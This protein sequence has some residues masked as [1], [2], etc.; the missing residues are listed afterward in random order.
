MGNIQKE[1][2]GASLFL[3]NKFF[4]CGL[5]YPAFHLLLVG[6]DGSGSSVYSLD[7]LP[8]RGG[9]KFRPF[10]ESSFPLPYGRKFLRIESR[11]PRCKILQVEKPAEHLT[12]QLF[13]KALRQ[14]IGARHLQKW[15]VQEN[16]LLIVIPDHTRNTG[17]EK[18]IQNLI[19]VLPDSLR[20]VY[21][22]VSTGSHSCTSSQLKQ[23]YSNALF[24]F[25]VELHTVNRKDWWKLGH[26]LRGT[27]I[28]I[29]PLLKEFPRVLILGGITLHYFAGFT[30]G[31]K[32][33]IPGL[34]SYSTISHNHSL[35]WNKEIHKMHTQNALRKYW[36][37]LKNPAAR[38]GNL[39][40]NPVHIDLMDAVQKIAEK[41]PLYSIQTV[42]SEP[43][44]IH[45]IFAGDW[46]K[47]FALG[48]QHIQKS[49]SIIFQKKF[50]LVIAGAGGYP[51][52][53]SLYQAHKAMDTASKFLK[54][55]GCLILSAELREG[56][57]P[58]SFQYW[59]QHCTPEDFYPKIFDDYQ[60]TMHSAY[61]FQQKLQKIRMILISSMAENEVKKYGIYP[62]RNITEA[63]SLA[64]SFLPRE[65]ETLILPSPLHILPIYIGR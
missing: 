43:G 45:K 12:A 55:G 25:P 3:R 39:R 31:R 52:D 37:D 24:H 33:L 42:Q 30:G 57:G 10:A 13:T 62:A 41:I 46:K 44:K 22:L 32:L 16:R 5:L 40:G 18:A 58:E 26:T 9:V 1:K 38:T 64:Q 63:L 59:L 65:A 20:E 6:W 47:T 23:R 4:L 17:W 11:I 49:Q 56:I 53:I 14:P 27:P 34:A 21:F 7:R 35:V 60:H 2:Y 54:P 29:N 28:E 15:L 50:D 61:A 36:H 51:L 19:S 8:V 48:S